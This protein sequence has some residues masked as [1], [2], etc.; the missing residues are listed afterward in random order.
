MNTGGPGRLP[1]YVPSVDMETPGLSAL[2]KCS[3]CWRPSF[4]FPVPVPV[5][6]PFPEL[7]NDSGNV[8]P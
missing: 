3:C 4:P 1:P 8:V 7:R 6:V 2:A 5:P